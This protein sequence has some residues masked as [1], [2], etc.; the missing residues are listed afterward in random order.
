M[1]HRELY[2]ALMYHRELYLA[3]MYHRELYLT[4]RYHKI[5]TWLVLLV[6]GGHA[7]DGHVGHRVP[8]PHR[9][10]EAVRRVRDLVKIYG[11][12]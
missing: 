5:L 10:L 11:D 6:D 8:A 2:L 12:Y 7:D 9:V 4:V 3:V 1:N